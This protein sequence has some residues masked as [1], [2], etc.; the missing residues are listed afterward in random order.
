[1]AVE[2]ATAL[3]A[4]G[5][6]PGTGH[7]LLVIVD[8]LD[9]SDPVAHL[10]ALQQKIGAYVMFAQSEQLEV[11][12]P[13]AAGRKRKIGVILQYEPPENIVPI[14]D[15][16]GAQLASMEIEFGYGPLPDGYEQ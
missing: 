12:L 6:E 2:D 7:A 13:E 15:G 10:N 9:W 1:M 16:L 11:E 5:I 8:D 14:L 3:D 4:L